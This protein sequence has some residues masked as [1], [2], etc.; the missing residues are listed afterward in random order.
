MFFWL[1]RVIWFSS[2]LHLWLFSHCA[3]SV[4]PLANLRFVSSWVVELS[5]SML[6]TGFPATCVGLTVGPS[7]RSLSRL[8]VVFVLSFILPAIRP[9]ADPNA[10]HIAILPLPNIC[11]A[12]SPLVR[13]ISRYFVVVP[14]SDIRRPICPIVGAS[15]LF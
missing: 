1:S 3:F 11:P 6:L 13:A 15:A 9:G 10:M 2:E 4:L 8:V 14:H 5:I 7:E 12:V